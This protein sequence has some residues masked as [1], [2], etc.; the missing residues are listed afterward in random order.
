MKDWNPAAMAGTYG[1]GWIALEKTRASL[2]SRLKSG[3]SPGVM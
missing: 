1:I 2:L 3:S